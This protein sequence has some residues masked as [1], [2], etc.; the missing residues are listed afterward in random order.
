MR[1]EVF[2]SYKPTL[3]QRV[4]I[5]LSRALFGEST[6]EAL[7]A[8]Y[9]RP[10]MLASNFFKMQH[11]LLRG[12]SEWSI[13]DR[14]LIGAFVAVYLKCDFCMTVHSYLAEPNEKPIDRINRLVEDPSDDIPPRLSAIL[15]LLE[16]LTRQPWNVTQEDFDAAS[17][18][19]LSRN[20]IEDAVMVCIDFN[21]G[22]RFVNALGIEI[23]TTKA[24]A[25]AR[26]I[27]K[28]T[29]YTIYT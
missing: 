29:G 3:L 17:R 2:G 9:Y 27:M 26:P 13:E 25:R 14:E 8:A 20:E 12:P 10:E 16:K 4:I 19:G 1:L 23:P 28:Y 22:A 6:V 18:A 7:L 24:L 11:H 5:A 15:P 21:I